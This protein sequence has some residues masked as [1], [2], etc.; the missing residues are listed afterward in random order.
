MLAAVILGMSTVLAY[1]L[2]IEGGARLG[3]R[4]ASFV[5]LNEVLFSIV[6]TWALLGELPAPI[7]FAGGALIL[8]EVV[9]VRL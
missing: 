7:Q 2:G 3:T 9:L 4:V 5:G 8:T 1:L 6:A